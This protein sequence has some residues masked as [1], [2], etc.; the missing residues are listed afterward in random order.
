M[1]WTAAALALLCLVAATGCGFQLRGSAQLPFDRV[2][3][4]LPQG[5]PLRRELASLM[6]A[7]GVE[8]VSEADGAKLS[9][10][11]NS[12]TRR[13]QS[14]GANARVREFEMVYELSF[15]LTGADGAE[16]VSQAR[17][18]IE[19]DYS[20]EQGEVLGVASEEEYVRREMTSDM[21]T[22]ILRRIEYA[23][24]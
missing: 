5:D 6:G 20:F 19:Q 11:R 4:D 17:L 2:W 15:S 14:V 23:S 12:L 13:I 9:F 24:R 8:L 1:R 10:Q 7:N 3:I 21:A 16:R 18:R 22:R